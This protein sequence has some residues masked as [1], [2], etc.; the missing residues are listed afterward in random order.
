M[1]LNVAK[2]RKFNFHPTSTQAQMHI[3][4]KWLDSLKEYRELGLS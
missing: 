3:I 4:A 2:D 1:K